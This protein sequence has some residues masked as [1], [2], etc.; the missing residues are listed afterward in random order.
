MSEE[1]VKWLA[2][3]A[4]GY[5]FIS[6]YKPA[7]AIRIYI[8]PSAPPGQRVREG[9][10]SCGE[11]GTV[12]MPRRECV[13]RPEPLPYPKPNPNMGERIDTPKLS[14]GGIVEGNVT[15]AASPT[16]ASFVTPSA[17]NVPHGQSTA[18]TPKEPVKTLRDE[19]AMILM[20]RDD[21]LSPVDAWD[22]AGAYITIRG[23]RE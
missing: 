7:E 8:N 19:V 5:W 10:E 4:A 16:S 3:D 11:R 13:E 15:E 6:D 23:K 9:V 2:L 14:T 22:Y 18:P 1:Q 21:E 12:E 17:G 20:A